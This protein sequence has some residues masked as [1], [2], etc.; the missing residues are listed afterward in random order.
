MNEST[1]LIDIVKANVKR[2]KHLV[3]EVKELYE[4]AD[5]IDSNWSIE[6]QLFAWAA[7]NLPEW[8][9]KTIGYK[10]A[11]REQ[12][13]EDKELK[14]LLALIIATNKDVSNVYRAFLKVGLT[15]EDFVQVFCA[16]D[17]EMA[18]SEGLTNGRM[19]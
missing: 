19:D 13:E 11:P 12:P 6:T 17:E 2:Y 14:K 1:R 7:L 3:P 16:L 18:E 8:T 5:E 10:K 9:A 4:R 15:A